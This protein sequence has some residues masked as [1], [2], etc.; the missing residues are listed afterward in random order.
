MLRDDL[1]LAAPPPHPSE[2][3][4]AN[5]NPLAITP[6]PPSRGVKISLCVVGP[7]RNSPN[8]SKLQRPNS[9]VSD[10]GTWSIKEQD[11]SSNSRS[12][13][14]DGVTALPSGP[15]TPKFGDV[16]SLPTPAVGKDASKRRKPKTS[17][18]KSNSSFIA[19]VTAHDS[20]NKRIQDHDSQGLFA[21]ASFNR[22]FEWLDLTP[23][24]N[25]KVDQVS[26]MFD[27]RFNSTLGRS[28]DQG[29][30][31]QINHNVP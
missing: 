4:S 8:A 7:R 17:L 21:F 16:D 27:T 22:T 1:R 25:S 31:C 19:R 30:F 2:V 10:L 23:N 13:E 11:E 3:P 18:I 6:V 26:R 29:H 5:P 15:R 28:P 12:S 14:G 20:M 24:L 9:T